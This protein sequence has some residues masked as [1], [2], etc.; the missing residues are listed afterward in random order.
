MAPWLNKWLRVHYRATREYAFRKALL[1]DHGQHCPQPAT[2]GR[3]RSSGT[4]TGS[5]S[6]RSAGACACTR[7]TVPTGPFACRRSL[8]PSPICRRGW[9]RSTARAAAQK[10]ADETGLSFHAFDLLQLNSADLKPK[11][12]SERRKRLVDLVHGQDET[13]PALYL[14]DQ[15][16]NGADL[17]AMCGKMH[18]EGIVSKRLDRPYISGPTKDWVKVKCAAW[19][20]G[21]RWRREAFARS[22]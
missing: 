20:E 1:P 6:S 2:A 8:R 19:K 4:A 17:L 13:I 7:A 9:H 10:P 3:T 5:R 16:P 15:F 22:N 18:L 14:P 21:N 12:L 11:P